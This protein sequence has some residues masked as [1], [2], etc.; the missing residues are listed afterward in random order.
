MLDRRLK[1]T[2]KKEHI[3]RVADRCEI[4]PLAFRNDMIFVDYKG[5]TA[6]YHIV[7]G[8]PKFLGSTA[9]DVDAVPDIEVRGMRLAA[10]RVI[11]HRRSQARASTHLNA[12]IE[13]TMANL[14]KPVFVGVDPARHG[15]DH[16]SWL[17]MMEPQKDPAKD[18]EA[19]TKAEE[20][21]DTAKADT[22]ASRPEEV[23]RKIAALA[24]MSLGDLA[25]AFAYETGKSKAESLDTSERHQAEDL[26]DLIDDIACLRFGT[27]FYNTNDTDE[28]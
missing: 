27:G 8:R 16:T 17:L 19:A 13:K 7:D 1:L 24:T 14:R 18:A 15:A 22:Y 26:A 20:P 4:R 6:A 23:S 11:N 28:N 3:E 12:M 5:S 2:A 25:L 10:Q 9:P 21:T